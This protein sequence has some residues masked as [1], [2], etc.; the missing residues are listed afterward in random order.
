LAL[1]Q[2]TLPP[3]R[4]ICIGS[5]EL[6]GHLLIDLAILAIPKID[7]AHPAGAYDADQPV[8]S[9][10]RETRRGCERASHRLADAASDP[11]VQSVEFEKGFQFSV[12]ISR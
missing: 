11:A 6:D 7:I 10:L 4:P 5:Q 12:D 3:R 9:T 8:R 2:E 1:L